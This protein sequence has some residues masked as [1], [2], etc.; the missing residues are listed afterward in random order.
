M[1]QPSDRQL[2]LAGFVMGALALFVAVGG[3][4]M[5]ERVFEK[6]KS[7][8]VTSKTIANNTIKS[9]D[10][11]KSGVQ[12][13]DVKDGTL[14]QADLAKSLQNGLGQPGPQGPQG[15][16][17]PPG[18]ATEATIADGSITT[19]KLAPNSVTASKIAD[20]AVLAS[21]IAASAVGATEIA[22]NAVGTSEIAD[23][24]VSSTDLGANS[25]GSSEVAN[26]SLVGDD[27]GTSSGIVTLNFPNMA[28]GSCSALTFNTPT[29][30]DGDALVVT[31]EATFTNFHDIYAEPD[32]GTA[33]RVTACS[34]F[35]GG[36][37]PGPADFAYIA[38]DAG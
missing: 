32:G 11:R 33:V 15:P 1:F 6:L 13:S 8:S 12:S 36:G 24:T 16:Q 31:P 29:S 28:Q 38:F 22:A 25:V 20:S 2:G 35:P 18:P 19:A 26:G 3:D 21:D 37:D 5:A 30:V 27:V 7:S 14:T 34:D 4:A 23:G 9:K 10:I 17:G